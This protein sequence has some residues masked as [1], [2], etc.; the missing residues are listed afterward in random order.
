MPKFEI[1]Q[2]AGGEW[3]WRLKAANGEIVGAGEGYKTRRGAT[4]GVEAARRAASRAKV[5]VLG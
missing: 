2:N 3:A 1:Y 5:V 4:S